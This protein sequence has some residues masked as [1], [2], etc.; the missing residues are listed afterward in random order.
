MAKY[1]SYKTVNGETVE[2]SLLIIS[3]NL[4]LP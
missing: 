1:L 3:N 4:T 2:W